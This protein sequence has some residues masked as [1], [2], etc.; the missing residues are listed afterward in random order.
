MHRMQRQMQMQ[1]GYK[2]KQKASQSVHALIQ[3]GLA[4][5][6]RWTCTARATSGCLRVQC[7]LVERLRGL[8]D[9]QCGILSK[10]AV[11]LQHHADALHRHDWEIFDAGVMCEAES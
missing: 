6:S 1:K 4:G 10:E 8:R 2:K 7:G 3:L 11:R 5:A 9:V